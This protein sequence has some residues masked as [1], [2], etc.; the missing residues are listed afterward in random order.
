MGIEYNNRET[1]EG[2]GYGNSITVDLTC[3]L[4]AGTLKKASVRGT[5]AEGVMMVSRIN[6]FHKLYFEPS[7]HT[8]VFG[9]K[10]R[11]GVLGQ[12]GAALAKGGVNIDD[13]RNPH[14]S[15]G[16]N[17]IAILKVNGAVP[18]DLIAGIAKEIKANMA[19][20]VEL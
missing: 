2:K 3:S 8:V 18:A 20:C 19:F 6:D 16:E 17:S 4:D 10:D 5:V 7:G 1:D 15:K 11:P 14:D 13:V 12:I 9:Y